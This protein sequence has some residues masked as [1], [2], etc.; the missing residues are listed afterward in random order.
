MASGIPSLS[1]SGSQASP[2]GSPSAFSCPG[3]GMNWQLSRTT[4][5]ARSGTPSPSVSTATMGVGVGAG[6]GTG[7]GAGGAGVGAG[8]GIGVGAGGAGA[9]VGAGAE[10]GGGGGEAEAAELPPVAEPPLA[11]GPLP[12]KS[13]PTIPPRAADSSPA[14]EPSPAVV[15]APVAG[16]PDRCSVASS[17]VDL[18]DGSENA[19]VGVTMSDGVPPRDSSLTDGSSPTPG[20]AASGRS[21]PNSTAIAPRTATSPRAA[22]RQR[23]MRPRGSRTGCVTTGVDGNETPRTSIVRSESITADARRQVSQATA[24]TAR[25]RGGSSAA[26]ATSQSPYLVW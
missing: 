20:R 1:S 2:R 8:V 6:V 15:L 17:A 13:L 12:V 14:V 19:A 21:V 4:P 16:V 7:V 5:R 11:A 9:G 26:P 3:L 18:S 10:V 22:M 25:S 24:W 23:P